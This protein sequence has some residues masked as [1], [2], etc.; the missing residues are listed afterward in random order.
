VKDGATFSDNPDVVC[1]CSPHR[2][3]ILRG[4]RVLFGPSCP[5]PFEDPVKENVFLDRT[6]LNSP[7]VC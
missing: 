1:V 6:L 4:P 3:E 7:T 2:E 5:I